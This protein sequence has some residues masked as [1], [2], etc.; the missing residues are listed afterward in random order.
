MIPDQGEEKTPR[1]APPSRAREPVPAARRRSSHAAEVAV[2]QGAYYSATGLWPLVSM[3]SFERV[4]G[5]KRDHWLVKTVGVLVTAV[6]MT[7]L[8]AGHRGRV[9]PDVALL[10]GLSAAALATIDV[11][12][13]AQR[14]I[15]PVYLLDAVPEVL[16]A[17]W[18]GPRAANAKPRTR[19]ADE[20]RMEPTPVVY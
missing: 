6:G 19:V 17:I 3:R 7:L 13:V 16:L 18:W 14:R 10:A 11:L 20:A 12:Y 5:P 8:R 15:S 4:T 2:L 1:H 9:H